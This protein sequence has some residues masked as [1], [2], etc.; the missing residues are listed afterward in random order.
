MKAY[1]RREGKLPCILHSTHAMV[2]WSASGT[3]RSALGE[4]CAISFIQLLFFSLSSY[5]STFH[6]IILSDDMIIVNYLYI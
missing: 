5:F 6:Q 2:E 1:V 4:I 3:G